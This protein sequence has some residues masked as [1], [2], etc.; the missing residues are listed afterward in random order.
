MAGKYKRI[1]IG[2][3][4]SLIGLFMILT[5][6]GL[7]IVDTTGDITCAGTIDDPCVSYFEV[8]NPTAR[9]IY[10]YNY[11]EVQLNFSP[12]IKGYNLYVLYYGKWHY[13]NFTMETR[14]GNIPKDRK[15]SFVFPRYSI[16][17]F[18]L[19]GYKHNPEDSVKW[20]IGTSGAELD[21]LWK[22]IKDR[23]Y[24]RSTET[25]CDDNGK[26]WTALYSGTKHI[27]ED[28]KWKDVEDARS[29]KGQ[30]FKV[31]VLE[32]DIEFPIEVMDFNYTSITVKLN[33]K[34]IKTFNESIPIRIWKGDIKNSSNYKKTHKKNKDERINF[35]LLN[36][37]E[38][39]TYD[40]KVGSIIEFGYN[41]TTIQLQDADTE[42]LE[43]VEVMAANERSTIMIKF[44]MS[45]VPDGNIIDA[46]SFNFY[47]YDIQDGLTDTDLNIYR[48]S[49]QTWTEGSNAA[50]AWGTRTDVDNSQTIVSS[51]GWKSFNVT[52]QVSNEW[53]LMNKMVTIG[54]ED[55]DYNIN[56]VD[57]I[58]DNTYLILG[59]Y[60]KLIYNNLLIYSKEHTTT[61]TR[62]YLNITY[63][64]DTT[65]PTYSDNSTN[66]T[67]AGKDIL[68]SLKWTDN[69]GLSGYIFSFDNGTGS[70][71]NDTWTAFSSN[72]ETI[73]VTKH[74]NTTVGTTIQWK[75]Y[76]NDTNDNW[77]SSSTYS[78]VTAECSTN[79][80]CNL[81]YKCITE[82]CVVQTDSE[83]LKDECTATYD[84]CDNQ[85]TRR[86]PDGLCDGAGACDIDDNSLAVQSGYVCKDGDNIN[87]NG[88]SNCGSG[89]AESCYCAIW[90]QCV[91]KACTKPE[92]YTGFDGST[93]CTVTNWQSK[94]T[95]ANVAQNVSIATT[96]NVASCTEN[97]NN[98]CGLVQCDGDASTPYYYGWNATFT[99]FYM[100]DT[101]GYCDGSGSCD[102]HAYSCPGSSVGGSTGVTCSEEMYK[103]YCS[104][105]TAGACPDGT[106]DITDSTE[107]YEYYY[108]SQPVQTEIEPYG[109]TSTK[110]MFT[111]N[112]NLTYTIDIYAKLSETTLGVTLKLDNEYNYDNSISIN[113]TYQLIYDNLSI[114]GTGYLWTWA[115]FNN[116]QSIWNPELNIIGV[117]STG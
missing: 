74:S 50:T 54:A 96:E 72:P 29:L 18:K 110:G 112:N 97:T 86:G 3:G 79:A 58:Y 89:D 90:Y 68:H 51:V 16:K 101:Q 47:V 35:G 81:C 77:A 94:G 67:A 10:I 107:C 99:C 62:P 15:Y 70:F 106:F 98:Y 55:P 22:G 41:S 105:T 52:T 95:D 30:G 42:N 44:N 102:S 64:P 45:S 1:Y 100:N 20:S 24:T 26:C 65:N 92:Y 23:S 4:T 13:T 21:P 5:A 91:I 71:T 8:R 69:S 113:T 61:A 9:S 76:A 83:D 80:D 25:K 111:I 49:H 108:A 82:N 37:E 117:N 114:S 84:D 59:G 48:I 36:Q 104:G 31:V 75:V 6:I 116:L 14:L 32:N 93:S 34:G 88:N 66:T 11:D 73:T 53:T 56:S 109:Q 17:K 87:S 33:P 2:A 103:V 38:I 12:D 40:F 60:H 63:S 28:N 19:V 39:K 7:Q 115:D 43:D 85:Y 57:G 27:Y 46:S 78:Y